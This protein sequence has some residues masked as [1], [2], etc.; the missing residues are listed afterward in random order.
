MQ[1][2]KIEKQKKKLTN[3]KLLVKD[4]K[5]KTYT[6]TTINKSSF[7]VKSKTTSLKLG[8]KQKLKITITKFL[9]FC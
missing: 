1:T 3:Q 9:K 4:K 6:N 5:H 2:G 8:H 7:L